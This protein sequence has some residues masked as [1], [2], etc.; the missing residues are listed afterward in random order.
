MS[1]L[2][3]IKDKPDLYVF[4]PVLYAA[5]ADTL[6]TPSEISRLTAFIGTQS[7]LT[8]KDSEVLLS[9]VNP[10]QP[11]APDEL[12]AWLTEIRS[13]VDPENVEKQSLIDIG[14]KLAEVRADGKLSNSLRGAR[15]SLRSMEDSLGFINGES[16]FHFYPESRQTITA[17][18]G[19]EVNYDTRNLT[20]IYQL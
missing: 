1:Y 12:K 17:Q 4:L 6:L 3:Y 9:T 13:V 7:W 16:V 2:T 10:A 19:T 20:R 14:F 15:Q 18:R 8:K 5:W 11:P